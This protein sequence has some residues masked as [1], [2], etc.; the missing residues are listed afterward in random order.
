MSNRSKERDRDL[1]RI[2]STYEEYRTSGRDRLWDARNPG[3]R[4]MAMERRDALVALVR[5]SLPE[6]GTVVDL[7]CGSGELL[8]DTL[9]AGLHADWIGVDLQPG[10]LASARTR[11]PAA[12]WVEASGDQ[13]PLPSESVDLVVASTLF[14]SLPSRAFEE[15]V[16]AEIGRVLRGGR[17][18]VWYDLRY[19]SPGNHA[20]HAISRDRIAQLFPGWTVELRTLTVL[21][22]LAR[23][24]VASTDTLYRLLSAVPP[25]RSHLAGRLMKLQPPNPRTS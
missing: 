6:G 4:R 2:R 3:Y 19:P 12:R 18:L 15:R 21:P 7:G 14:S 23:R 9:E 1:D 5:A 24:L 22:P 16:A 25:L 13:L 8:G 20:V 17:W 11:Y 10:V